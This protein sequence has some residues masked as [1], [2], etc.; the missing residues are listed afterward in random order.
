MDYAVARP[1]EL[2]MWRKSNDCLLDPFSIWHDLILRPG[3]MCEML[4]ILR[5]GHH[6]ISTLA[7]VDWKYID[8]LA[9][10][11]TYRSCCTIRCASPSRNLDVSQAQFQGRLTCE[12]AWSLI[13]ISIRMWELGT[14]NIDVICNCV[15]IGMWNQHRI[16]GS[17]LFIITAYCETRATFCLGADVVYST[18]GL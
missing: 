2:G 7:E 1:S 11:L 8:S 3:A 13:L 5:P 17:E 12:F 6:I 14:R 18:D 9:T 16:D 15:R 10:G 4:S